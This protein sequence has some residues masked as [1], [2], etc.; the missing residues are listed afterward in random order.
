[1]LRT[2]G[3]NSLMWAS[4]RGHIEIVKLLLLYNADVDIKNNYYGK[5]SL[6]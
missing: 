6:I 1:M 2:Y 3:Q 4:E 5:S